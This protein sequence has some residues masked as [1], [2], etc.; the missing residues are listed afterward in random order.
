MTPYRT[1]VATRR[2]CP[3]TQLLRVVIDPSDAQ[4]ARL[5][6][7]PRRRLPGRGAWITPDLG[8]MELA[9]RRRAFARALRTSAP[10]DTGQVRQYLMDLAQAG[11]MSNVTKGRPEH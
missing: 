10:V 11:S 8:A 6:P 5:I 7:D 9:E 1:C 3:D 2:R 4:R